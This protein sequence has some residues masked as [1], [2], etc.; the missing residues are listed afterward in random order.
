MTQAAYRDLI[1]A[2]ARRLAGA[3][4]EPA[5]REARL[6]M[7]LAAELS[8]T[9]LIA[10]EP[11]PLT[12][13]GIRTRFHLMLD[14]R[15]AREPFAHIAGK[16]SFYGLDFISDARALVPRP[17]SEAVVEAALERMPRGR[18]VEL[19]DLGTGSGCLLVALLKTRGGATGVGIEVDPAAASLAQENLKR[20]SLTDRAEIKVRDWALWQDWDQMDLIISNPP[21]IV[22]SVIETLEPEVRSHDPARALDG[23]ADGLEAYRSLISVGSAR[24]KAGA[25]LVLEIGFDQRK[26]VTELMETADFTDIS[27]TRDLSG[28]DRVVCGQRPHTE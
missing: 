11:E 10:I 14:R 3:G 1:D 15:V 6:L 24:M 25:W 4:V 13:Q 2:A 5:R 26:G 9:E 27:V 22:S 21:Y 18:G 16:A 7:Q 19:A 12:D 20:H 28:H 17:D 23:G 8:P